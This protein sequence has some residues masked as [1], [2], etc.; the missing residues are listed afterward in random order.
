MIN[1]ISC[2]LETKLLRVGFHQFFLIR[3]ILPEEDENMTKSA[4]L[5]KLKLRIA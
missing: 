2:K 5:G 3:P 4:I 1:K